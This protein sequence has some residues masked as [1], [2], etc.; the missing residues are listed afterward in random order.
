MTTDLITTAPRVSLHRR[1]RRWRAV[2]AASV[3]AVAPLSLAACGGGDAAAG[4]TSQA[5]ADDFA[6]FQQCL[7]ENGVEMGAPPDQGG[8]GGGD[9]A[10]MPDQEAMAQAQEACA[11]L[12]PEGMGQGGPG[13]GQGGP[14]GEELTAYVECLADN[15]VEVEGPGAG[16]E[17]PSGEPPTGG[18]APNDGEAGAP[19]EGGAMFGLDESDPEVAA[20]I[21]ACAELAPEPPSG[22]APSAD[23]SADATQS[24]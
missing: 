10:Q 16:G 12:A 7:A 14:G 18:E 2:A 19:P 24:S 22:A 15:G 13:M 1:S 4:A 9:A 8:A 6:A 11:D 5:G 3:L 21:E 17:P 20:A 23:D